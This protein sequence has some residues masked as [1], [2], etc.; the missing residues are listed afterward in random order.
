[1]LETS[2]T[3]SAGYTCTLIW[4]NE[5]YRTENL[6]LSLPLHLQDGRK[7]GYGAMHGIPMVATSPVRHDSPVGMNPIEIQSYEP[8]WKALTDFALHT[9]LDRLNPNAPHFQHLVNQVS[10]APLTLPDRLVCVV[11]LGLKRNFTTPSLAHSRCTATPTC[12]RHQTCTACR[13]RG[14]TRAQAVNSPLSRRPAI[15]APR[16]RPLRPETASAARPLLT[17]RPICRT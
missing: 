10:D 4:W 9:D 15:S 17:T 11:F 14:R 7:M 2:E 3:D 6:T 5:P 16:A 13:L 8:P 1:M 12:P